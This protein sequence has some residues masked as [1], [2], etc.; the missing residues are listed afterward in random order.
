[1]LKHIDWLYFITGIVA[2]SI[3]VYV[4][5]PEKKVIVKYPHPETINANI[6]RDTNGVCYK[7]NSKEVSCSDYADKMIPYPLQE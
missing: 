3:L 7:F 4:Y 1:M 6:Y 2:G 5:I